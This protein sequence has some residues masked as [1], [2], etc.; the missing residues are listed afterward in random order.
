MKEI[1]YDHELNSICNSFSE[2]ITFLIE[3][4]EN[5]NDEY[6]V[7][8]FFNWKWKDSNHVHLDGRQSF[9][10]KIKQEILDSIKKFLLNEETSYIII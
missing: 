2:N 9:Y 10:G 3:N 4:P 1:I 5:K 8:I 7:K 6:Y